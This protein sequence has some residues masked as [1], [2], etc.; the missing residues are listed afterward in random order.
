MAPMV[1]FFQQVNLNFDTAARFTDHPRGLLEQ[2]KM[3][4][5][6][7][8]M[9]FPV[10]RAD[11]A[12]EVIHA[13][14]AEHSHHKLP[15]KGG[16]RYSTLVNED[17]VT[18]LAALMTYKCAIVDV[19]FGGAKGGVQVDIRKYSTDELE[20]ITR[21]YTYE[22]VQKSFIGPGIDVPAPDYGTGEREMAWIAGTYTSLNPGKLDALACVTGKPLEQGGIRGRRAATGRGVYF[23]IREACS[24]SE[25][26]NMLGLTPG[27]QGKRVSRSR[28]W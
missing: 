9:T 4:N 26:M 5:T 6:V 16:I 23:G 17:E 13:W 18:A 1:P 22:L 24:F 7:C 3:C 21:R 15:T 12:I 8:H 19:P 20:R 11:G 2:I 14:R 28:I 25:D 27:L 10:K